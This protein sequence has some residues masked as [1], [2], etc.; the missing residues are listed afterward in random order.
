MSRTMSSVI[1]GRYFCP[2]MTEMRAWYDNKKSLPLPGEASEKKVM[3]K[4]LLWEIE[5][6]N[7]SDFHNSSITHH[8]L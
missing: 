5:L 3:R 7:N 4:S 8:I 6:R 1:N 2:G